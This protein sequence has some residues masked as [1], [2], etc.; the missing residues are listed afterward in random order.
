M[1]Y[2][3]ALTLIYLTKFVPFDCLYQVS[4]PDLWHGDLIFLYVT[5]FWLYTFLWFLKPLFQ[6]WNDLHIIV[7]F[8]FYAKL[9]ITVEENSII[10][11][12]I[13]TTKHQQ[14][15]THSLCPVFTSLK[16]I[17]SSKFQTF[18]YFITIYFIKIYFIKI[19]FKEKIFKTA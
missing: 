13:P 1:L 5:F 18:Y 8:I 2:I 16:L 6:Y 14:L 9:K 15:L 11:F 19:F 7:F 12:Y 10:S 4:L 3:I 17:I